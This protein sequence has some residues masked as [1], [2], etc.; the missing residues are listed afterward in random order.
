MLSHN[1][2]SPATLKQENGTAPKSVLRSRS[3]RALR[4]RA[5]HSSGQAYRHFDARKRSAGHFGFGLWRG[6]VFKA[7]RQD[8]TPDT[9]RRIAS[10][11][12]SD[13]ECHASTRFLRPVSI[14]DSW[15][16]PASRIS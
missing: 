6:N 16:H 10:L 1:S 3:T 5:S 13:R 4:P 9:R 7:E 11:V 8:Y 15:R 2:R 12:S 14:R